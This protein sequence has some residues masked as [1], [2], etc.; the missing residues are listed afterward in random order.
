MAAVQ[1]TAD[2][3]KLQVESAG[4]QQRLEAQIVSRGSAVLKLGWR[5]LLVA[6]GGA[7]ARVQLNAV[8]EKEGL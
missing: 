4:M 5:A 7:G 3:E 1:R 6:Q 2:M 8:L